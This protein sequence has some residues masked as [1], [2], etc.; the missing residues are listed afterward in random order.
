MTRKFI[1]GS[2]DDPFSLAVMDDD[3]PTR[4][5]ELRFELT[6]RDFNGE[7][8]TRD[9]LSFVEVRALGMSI[10]TFLA[11]NNALSREYSMR[12]A[13]RA[14]SAKTVRPPRQPATDK[15]PF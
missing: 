1:Y 15:L 9:D 11:Q 5:A 2:H 4:G 3:A 12:N 7:R 8:H 6:L 14:A 10:T 13:K